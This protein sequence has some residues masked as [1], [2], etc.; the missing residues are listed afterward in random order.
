MTLYIENIMSVI[1]YTH[2]FIH[3]FTILGHI[4]GVAIKFFL[5]IIYRLLRPRLKTYI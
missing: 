3:K 5:L 1:L 4:T 2:F